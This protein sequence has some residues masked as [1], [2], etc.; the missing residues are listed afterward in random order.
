MDYIQ[1][2]ADLALIPN[3]YAMISVAYLCTTDRYVP[4][5][6]DVDDWQGTVCNETEYELPVSMKEAL[7]GKID[8]FP[9]NILDALA[10]FDLML[11]AVIDAQSDACRPSLITESLID[12]RMIFAD[13]FDKLLFGTIQEGMYA[14]SSCKWYRCSSMTSGPDRIRRKITENNRY[15]YTDHDWEFLRFCSR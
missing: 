14:L 2:G 1:C 8:N 10:G 9:E 6:G 15:K 13:H 5:S 7:V 3:I 11:G 12:L 4:P